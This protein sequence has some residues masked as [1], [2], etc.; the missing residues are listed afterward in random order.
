M[1]VIDGVRLRTFNSCCVHGKWREEP[2]CFPNELKQVMSLQH[3]DGKVFMDKIRNLNSSCA[4][5]SINAETYNFPSGGVYCYRVH[6][7][8]I[9]KFNTAGH[10]GPDE[11]PRYGQLYVINSDDA[12]R[13]RRQ[14]PANRGVPEGERTR[15][16]PKQ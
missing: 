3:P 6:G 2:L 11:R 1:E 12:L 16:Q 10:P 7:A 8:L 4:F 5:A 9:N 13:H 14:E 15:C